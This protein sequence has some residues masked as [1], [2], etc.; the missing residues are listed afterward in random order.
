E[1]YLEQSFADFEEGT[2]PVAYSEK[3]PAMQPLVTGQQYL[4]PDY[5]QATDAD[6]WVE[7]GKAWASGTPTDLSKYV[8]KS[9]VEAL[10]MAGYDNAE[11]LME[12]FTS[13]TK[14][15]GQIPWEMLADVWANI[16]QSFQQP[17]M[18]KP[19]AQD[20]AEKGGI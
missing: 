7:Y 19:T 20:E 6:Y 9:L 1:K 12:V 16:G 3:I 4:Q 13:E 18:Y 2:T 17:G 14:K 15:R 10:G 11:K 8:A 5:A